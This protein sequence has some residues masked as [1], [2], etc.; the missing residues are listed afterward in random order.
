MYTKKNLPEKDEMVICTI[1]DANP[2]SVFAILD[3]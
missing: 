1:R 2:S 3:E